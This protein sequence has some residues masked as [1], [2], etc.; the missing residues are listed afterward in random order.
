MQMSAM[1]SAAAPYGSPWVTR[2]AVQQAG[3][4]NFGLASHTGTDLVLQYGSVFSLQDLLATKL[5]QRT[6]TWH[7]GAINPFSW[8]QH[9][10]PENWSY[11]LCF[12]QACSKPELLP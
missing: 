7:G 5:L 2:E 8:L 12:L 1:T 11:L 6:G 10:W 4:L 9:V 3:G